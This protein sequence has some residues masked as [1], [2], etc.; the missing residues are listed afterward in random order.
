MA[1]NLLKPSFMVDTF[2][3]AGGFFLNDPLLP[4]EVLAEDPLRSD[5]PWFIIALA[6]ERCKKGDFAMLQVLPTMVK[7]NA[8]AHF[9][10]ACELLLGHA[11]SRS[12]TQ[13]LYDAF[14]AEREDGHP[15]YCRFLCRIF[16]RS[17]QLWSVPLMLELFAR[18][19]DSRRVETFEFV[20]DCC[21]ELLDE[22][23]YGTLFDSSMPS[24][25]FIYLAIR[26]YEELCQRFGTDLVPIRRGQIFSVHSMARWMHQVLLNPDI[27]RDDVESLISEERY[28]FEAATGID[29]RSWFSELT[30]QPLN[31]SASL[32]RFLESVEAK[33]YQ[34]GMRYFF[35]HPVAR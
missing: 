23:P 31:A 4:P 33:T 5:R 35:K 17:M 3:E 1:T 18:Y 21:S 30:L 10:D 8:G 26:R 12:Q 7:R 32:E 14:K 9:L 25:E 20:H 15:V 22:E 16:V 29:C 24:K 11:G 6:L 2:A 27:D 13:G 28:F 34:P 19:A